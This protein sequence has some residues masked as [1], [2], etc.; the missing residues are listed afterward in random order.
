V[1][2]YGKFIGSVFRFRLLADILGGS[3]NCPLLIGG[4]HREMMVLDEG[5]TFETERG[6][7]SEKG[8]SVAKSRDFGKKTRLTG[9][10][11]HTPREFTEL[12]TRYEPFSS[13]TN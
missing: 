1:V 11:R 2:K 12:F 8:E 7:G 9:Y 3:E 5:L 10:P 4:F 13:S 6:H